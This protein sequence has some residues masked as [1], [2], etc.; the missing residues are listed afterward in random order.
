[1]TATPAESPAWSRRR[2][3]LTVIA[4]VVVQAGL[5]FWLGDN[6]PVLP[7][8]A[9]HEPRVFL[10]PNFPGDLAA[11]R[12]PTLFARG[13]AHGFSGLAWQA[14]PAP[15]FRPAEWTEPPRFLAL[16]PEQLG[17]LVRQLVQSNTPA[18]LPG[19]GKPEPTIELPDLPVPVS[20]LPARS[21]LRVEGGLAGRRLRSPFTLPSWPS[22][23]LVTSS[24]VRVVVDADGRT[25]SAALLSSST[26]AAADQQALDLA[27]SARFEPRRGN[28]PGS[29]VKQ[30]PEIAWGELVFAWHTVPLPATNAPAAKP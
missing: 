5:V 3:T 24:V 15:E 27:R 1:M 8:R 19:A 6:F 29:P 2:W 23:D 12:D 22:R 25:Q 11:L 18:P 16:R 14:L 4:V 17:A 10:T 28:A 30:A 9:H 26:S 20:S 7:R 13:N 21:E